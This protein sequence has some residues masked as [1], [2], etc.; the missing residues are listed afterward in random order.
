M[1]MVDGYIA[2]KRKKILVG[3]VKVCRW[4]WSMA[5]VPLRRKKI[6]VGRV[7]V[8]KWG[9]LV[10]RGPL[11]RNKRLVGRR[12]PWLGGSGCLNGNGRWP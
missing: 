2:F 11:K 7:K 8:S 5:M 1:V 9:W 12:T 3:R 6:L 10:A 4:G